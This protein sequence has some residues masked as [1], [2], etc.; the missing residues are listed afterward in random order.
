MFL[1]D[2]N[3][4][5]NISQTCVVSSELK[6]LKLFTNEKKQYQSNCPDVTDAFFL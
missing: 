2:P 4:T 5:G 3:T 6:R 1:K